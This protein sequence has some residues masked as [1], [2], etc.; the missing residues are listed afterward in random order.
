MPLTKTQQ[1]A[2]KCIKFLNDIIDEL[3]ASQGVVDPA[4]KKILE[5]KVVQ[6]KKR[7]EELKKK[8]NG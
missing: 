5:R 4:R 7:I 2:R 6:Y 8:I 1:Q 3:N